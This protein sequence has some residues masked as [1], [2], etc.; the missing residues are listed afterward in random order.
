MKIEDPVKK[1]LPDAPATWDNITISNLLSHTS[2]IPNFTGFP[3]Y[4][5]Q[6]PFSTTP[7]KLVA[8]FREKPLDFQPG[9]KWSYSNSG[10][11]LLG[12]LIEKISGQTYEKFLQENIFTPMAMKDSGYDSNSAVILKRSV[13]ICAERRGPRQRG[14]RSYEHPARCG[15]ALFHYRR[16]LSGQA[17]YPI[18]AES[19]TKF[20]LKVA[21][22][23]FDFVKDESG[24]V[25]HLILHQA[26][27]DRK[28]TRTSDTVR[29]RKEIKVSRDVLEKY[30]GTYELRLGFDI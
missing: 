30:V 20:F 15:S 3:D 7:E 12:Y 21:D 23:Q 9:E 25:S 14:L 26:G 11:V 5:S 13:R 8:R 18:F 19:E 28:A 10:F 29:E 6:E 27:R 4:A 17:K 24:K 16:Q 22:A 2:G 1:Y